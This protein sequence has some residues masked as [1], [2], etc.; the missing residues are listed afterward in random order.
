MS[1]ATRDR[2]FSQD[3]REVRE[4]LSAMSIQVEAMIESAMR[5]LRTGDVKLAQRT[6]ALDSKVN[7]TEIESDELCLLILAKRQPL[8]SDLRFVAFS[9]KMV[10]DLERIGDLAVNICERVPELSKEPPMVAHEGLEKLAELVVQMVRKAI[11]AFVRSDDVAATA[12]LACDADVD[13]LYHQVFESLVAAMVSDPTKVRR[14]VHLT[15]VAKWLERIGDHA[16][17]LAE[18]A[19]FV[20]KGKDVRHTIHASMRPGAFSE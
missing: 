13:A 11:D 4:K 19:I 5:A 10:T 6:I 3:L 9:L 1:G 12:V 18:T 8:A 20:M 17:N 2:A 7:Q 16:A 14:G 15:S